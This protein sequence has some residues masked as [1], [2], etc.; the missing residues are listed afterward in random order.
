[1]KTTVFPATRT[2][3]RPVDAQSA[4]CGW[5]AIFRRSKLYFTSFGVSVF[6]SLNLTPERIVMTYWLFVRQAPFVAS[7]GM[8]LPVSGLNRNAVSYA[9]PTVPVE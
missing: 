8:K 9:S 2:L 6:P 5:V 3:L 7:H 1:M 4:F